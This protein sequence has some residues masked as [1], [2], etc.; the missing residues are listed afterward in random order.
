MSLTW[1]TQTRFFRT[2]HKQQAAE[3][4]AAYPH[5][6][7]VWCCSRTRYRSG[8]CQQH[9]ANRRKEAVKKRRVKRFWIEVKR[10]APEVALRK[11]LYVNY[12]LR[13]DAPPMLVAAFSELLR[14]RQTIR[15]LNK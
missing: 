13:K 12:R 4:M 1:E 3:R 5:L 8:L 6:C 7:V 10:R 2:L 14:A 11:K 15:S 9:I